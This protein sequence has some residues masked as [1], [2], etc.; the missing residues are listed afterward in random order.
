MQV[1]NIIC[2][3]HAAE[4]RDV[5]I[6]L[7]SDWFNYREDVRQLFELMVRAAGRST[8]EMPDKALLF[9][10][11]YPDKTY[12]DRQLRLLGSW[13]TDAIEDYFRWQNQAASPVSALTDLA[14]IYRKKNLPALF[15]KNITLAERKLNEQPLRNADYWQQRHGLLTETFRFEAATKRTEAMHLQDIADTLDYWYYAQ[16]LRQVCTALSHQNVFKTEYHFNLLDEVLAQVEAGHLQ[17]HPAIGMYYHCYKVLT[18]PTDDANFEAFRARILEHGHHFPEDEL[19][20][21]YVLALNFCTR[22]VNEGSQSHIR[23]GFELYKAGFD[24]KIFVV[25]GVLSRFTYRNATALGLLLGELDWVRAFL[26]EFRHNLESK[27][28]DSTYYF[29]LARWEYECKHYDA[30][31]VLL[32]NSEYEDLL[33]ALAAKTLIAKILYITDAHDA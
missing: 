8:P 16:K 4:I 26:D 23:A 32:Q 21:L 10:K 11:I 15:K 24:N 31:L 5:R 17:E 1:F 7:R 2:A 9:Q 28:R 13:L 6:L 18:Q 22:R 25:N 19:R 27:Y 14:A 30:A 29:N 33:A 20:D 12:D 3:L